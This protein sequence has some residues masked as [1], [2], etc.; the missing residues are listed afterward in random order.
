MITLSYGVISDQLLVGVYPQTP[1]HV[2]HLKSIGVRGVLNLQSDDDLAQRGVSW[3]LFWR[4]YTAQGLQAV[5]YPIPD[6]SPNDLWKHLAGGVEALERLV[7][8]GGRRVYLHCTAGINRSPTVA[9]AWL[10]TRHGLSRAEAEEQV[11]AA[12]P[13]AH[14]YP[15]V[16][17]RWERQAGR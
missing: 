13:M 17:D 6:F 9:I 3:D 8:P 16:L 11:M 4:F 10:M 15:E 7:G 5:R 12:R 2:L 1:E 14:P